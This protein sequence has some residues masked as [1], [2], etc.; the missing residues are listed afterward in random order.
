MKIRA[1]LLLGYIF[2]SLLIMIIS[3]VAVYG[4]NNIDGYYQNIIQKDDIVIVK[5]REIQFYFTGQANDERG[6][7]LTGK[8]E[9][10]Q[11]IG[12]KSKQIKDRIESIKKIIT[13]EQEQELLAKIDQEHS[14]F[15]QVNFTVI[16]LYLAGKP[17]EAKQLSFS[18]G[19]QTRKELETSFN[20]LVTTEAEMAKDN[21]ISAAARLRFL[22]LV[23][24]SVSAGAVITGIAAGLIMTQQITRP[25]NL[26]QQELTQL[27]HSGGD[28]T[29]RID[30]KGKDEISQLANTVN[31]FL[32]SLRDIMSRIM[33]NAEQVAASS[34]ELTAS[35]GQSAL[36]ANQIASSINSVA[37]GA[38]EQ[39]SAVNETSAIVEQISTGIQQAAD[40]SNKIAKQSAEAVVKAKDGGNTVAKAVNQMKYIENTVNS[41]AEVVAKLG[42]RSKEISQIVDTIASLAAQTNLL[43]L[44][45][46][47]EAAQ[48]GEKGRGF[49]V[50][51]DEVKKLAEQSHEAT[52]KI[53][54]MIGEVQSDTDHAVAAMNNGTREVKNGAE[55]VVAAGAAFDDIVEMVSRVSDQVREISEAIRQIAGGSQRIVESVRKIETLSESSASEAQTVSAGTEEQLAS[56]EEIS[57]SSE[58]LSTLAQELRAAVDKFRV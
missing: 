55:V 54:E 20:E 1:K 49:A 2:V 47:I 39:L 8:P 45:A 11:E 6:F 30:I 53:A 19:R 3:S 5:L 56:M 15:T 26:L 33:S 9:F 24:L 43:A 14:K 36:A 37:S 51:A 12:D 46:A 42:A 38:K 44:N 23:I 13:T 18:D 27:A 48:A 34:E 50:V 58:A 29:Q 25:I 52:Q 7:L 28:L 40:N 41:S 4:F 22:L 21:A 10:K 57:S 32:A 16:D 17:E 31:S 35:S